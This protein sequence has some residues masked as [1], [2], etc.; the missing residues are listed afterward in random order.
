MGRAI[1]T[2]SSGQAH[3]ALIDHPRGVIRLRTI[4][5]SI[6]LKSAGTTMTI[7]YAGGV[8]GGEHD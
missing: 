1:P 8:E 7:G 3:A 5:G 6:D 4:G 2:G